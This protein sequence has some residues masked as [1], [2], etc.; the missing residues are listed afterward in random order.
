[1]EITTYLSS[2][3]LAFSARGNAY[4][5]MLNDLD[6]KLC[7]VKHVRIVGDSI[8]FIAQN[9]KSIDIDKYD[10]FGRINKVYPVLEYYRGTPS[11]SHYR[12][13][14][15]FIPTYMGYHDLSVVSNETL[16]LLNISQPVVNEY[17]LDANNRI[18]DNEHLDHMEE[19]CIKKIKQIINPPNII[20]VY[21]N[22]R[23][24]F[25]RPIVKDIDPIDRDS[26]SDDEIPYEIL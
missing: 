18:L 13:E 26:E 23:R 7:D 19:A 5:K 1:M 6:S 8:Q 17:E 3:N 24:V 12:S 14:T 20:W 25:G 21:G 2:G 9:P 10:E 4:I 11:V 22:Q 16:K 15:E